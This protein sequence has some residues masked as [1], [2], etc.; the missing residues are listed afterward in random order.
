MN[1]FNADGHTRVATAEDIKV[2]TVLRMVSPSEG[3]AHAFADMIV[4]KIKETEYGPEVALAVPRIEADEH[5]GAWFVSVS[6]FKAPLYKL[7]G[8]DSL[9][10]VVLLSTGAVEC[11]TR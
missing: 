6:E 4:T 11:R 8:D 2:G 1:K 7:L 3:V 9:F 5:S 10:R